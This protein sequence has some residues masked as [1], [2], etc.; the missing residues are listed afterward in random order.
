MSDPPFPPQFSVTWA[1][2]H[3]LLHL[4]GNTGHDYTEDLRACPE[5]VAEVL[6]EKRGRELSDLLTVYENVAIVPTPG[7]QVSRKPAI[8]IPFPF[9]QPP[10][11]TPP[12]EEPLPRGPTNLGPPA[13]IPS[14]PPSPFSPRKP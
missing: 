14:P 6:G 13:T 12:P 4:G 2:F 1:E 9:G 7:S 5:L 11:R 10:S 8:P 3:E